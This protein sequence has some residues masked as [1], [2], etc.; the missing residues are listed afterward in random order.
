MKRLPFEFID[1]LRAMSA[2][3]DAESL[4]DLDRFLAD[5][6]GLR[7]RAFYFEAITRFMAQ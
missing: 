6:A 7:A 1:V 5:R 3:I 4:H 2:D